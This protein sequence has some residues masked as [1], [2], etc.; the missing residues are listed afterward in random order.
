MKAKHCLYDYHLCSKK[1]WRHTPFCKEHYNDLVTIILPEQAPAQDGGAG[2]LKSLI[3]LG[4]KL[5][6]QS[7]KITQGLTK[8]SRLA[9]TG[10]NKAEEASNLINQGI[11]RAQ[12]LTSRAQALADNSSQ[13]FGNLY[14]NFVGDSRSEETRDLNYSEPSL[15]VSGPL[16]PNSGQNFQT[17]GDYICLK[18]DFV[19]DLRVLFNELFAKRNVEI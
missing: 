9:E 13:Q 18:K 7:E 1:R 5:A 8:A 11:G 6:N 14:N 12:E 10:L 15:T 19:R 17:F 16:A 3:N 4:S 2:G